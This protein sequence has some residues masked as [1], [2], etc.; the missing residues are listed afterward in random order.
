M[1]A[2]KGYKPELFINDPSKMVSHIVQPILA[3]LEWERNHTLTLDDLSSLTQDNN[4][5]LKGL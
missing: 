4:H 3:E 1:V 5:K 2:S